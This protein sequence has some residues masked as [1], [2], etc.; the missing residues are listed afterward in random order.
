MDCDTARQEM[1]GDEVDPAV[2]VHVQSCASC[3]SEAEFRGRV[4]T[5]LAS[6]PRVKAPEGLLD[7]VMGTLRSS[8]AARRARR[9]VLILHAWEIGWIGAACLLAMMLLTSLSPWRSWGGALVSEEMPMRLVTWAMSGA[10]PVVRAWG[11]LL[12]EWQ[13]PHGAVS[14]LWGWLPYSWVS[15]AAG[16]VLGLFLLLTWQRKVDDEREEVHAC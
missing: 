14:A 6:M 10:E 11:H 2:A 1:D 13:A 3:R 15:G 16:F 7:Q 12:R 4:A 8:P 5:A 9:R